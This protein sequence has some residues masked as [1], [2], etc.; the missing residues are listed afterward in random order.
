MYAIEQAGCRNTCNE[1]LTLGGMSLAVAKSRARV[2]S[3]PEPTL[4]QLSY[5]PVPLGVLVTSCLT[6]LSDAKVTNR[7]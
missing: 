7:T 1:T 4:N 6:A 5:I 2:S 3:A